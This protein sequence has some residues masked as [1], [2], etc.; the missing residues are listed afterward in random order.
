MLC[1]GGL[2]EDGQIFAR[3]TENFTTL[4]NDSSFTCL[5]S[6]ILYDIVPIKA[7]R[8]HVH[9]SLRSIWDDVHAPDYSQLSNLAAPA[10]A[11]SIVV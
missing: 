10:T 5:L 6:T 11:N 2:A 7:N 1:F 4:Q 9:A 3:T 8:S